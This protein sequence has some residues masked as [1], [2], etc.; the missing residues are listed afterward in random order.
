[1]L[2]PEKELGELQPGEQAPEPITFDVTT[3][4]TDEGIVIASVPR[5][6]ARPIIKKGKK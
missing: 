5:I 2:E 3:R 6:P 4:D 1:M